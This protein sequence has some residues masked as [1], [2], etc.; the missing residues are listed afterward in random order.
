MNK[1]LIGL[2]VVLFVAVGAVA[3]IVVLDPR[4][5]R[6]DDRLSVVFAGDTGMGHYRS[7][8]PKKHGYHRSFDNM[9]SDLQ[10]ADYLV[11]NL[12]MV[13]S[14]DH[15]LP[16][17]KAARQPIQLPAAAPAYAEEKFHAFG[18]A[19]NHL[20]DYFDT[21]LKHTIEHLDSAGIKHFGAG[22][23]EAEARA[24]LILEDKGVKV[25]VLAYFW[26]RSS[27]VKMGWYAKG[28]K[29]G[30]ALM[31]EKNMTEDIRKLKETVDVVVV[32]AHWGH[33]YEKVT[34]LQIKLAHQAV[35]AG[36]DLII[37]H[38]A[39][40]AQRVDLIDNVPVV[41]SIGNFIWDSRGRFSIF[42]AGRYAFA[43]ITRVE[44]DK[45]G[46]RRI[47]ITPYHNNNKIVKYI[48][49]PV[50]SKRAKK[51]FR[52]VFRRIEVQWRMYGQRAVWEI[53]QS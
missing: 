26:P 51:L 27:Y 16:S 6:S 5:P 22:F 46:P 11:G 24:P 53:P 48:P 14:E 12:E 36:A 52:S 47:T 3:I 38:G 49:K 43:L 29:P 20:L 10:D 15:R 8:W 2:L 50:P 35:K 19:N 33:N 39:H 31:N 44:F 4:A 32:F 21:G 40:M 41:Y 37:G 34:R 13:I 42:K 25:G 7:S 1:K 45:N 30:V 18:L 9:R 28:D 17:A 23:D